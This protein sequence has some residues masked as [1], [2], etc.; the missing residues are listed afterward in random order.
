M[1]ETP[2]VAYVTGASRGIGRLLVTA[3]A[4]RGVRTVGFARPSGE[5]EALRTDGGLVT[6]I[7][8]D[9]TD[10]RSVTSAFDHAVEDAGPPTLLVTC[11][12]TIDPLGPISAVDPDAWWHAVS[13][14][15]RG[16]ML[17]AR[18]AA[19]IMVEQ[20]CG[21]IVTVY[22][23]LGDDGR[24]HVSA[25]AAAKAAVARFTETLAAELDG[26]GVVAVCMHPGFVRTPMTEHLAFHSEGQR[27]LPAF[28]VD[29]P[30]RWGDGSTAVELVWQIAQGRA[31]ELTGRIIHIDDDL[32][33]LVAAHR[34][35]QDRGRLRIVGRP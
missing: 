19:N 28:G 16:T 10:P 14:D 22:G 13:V 24:P 27:W 31:D 7:P 15:L 8:M 12:G 35:G 6:P 17:C 3:L 34:T 20:N 9:V 21:T 32:D 33:A 23:N 1:T 26:T 29:G 11:A 30:A 25:F 4:S 2:A 18:A 5:L